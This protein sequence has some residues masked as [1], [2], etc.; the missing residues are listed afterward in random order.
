MRKCK[1][2]GKWMQNRELEKPKKGQ[3]CGHC[4]KCRNNC[5]KKGKKSEEYCDICVKKE[6]GVD[7]GGRR[8]KD[9]ELWKEP[10]RKKNLT[11]DAEVPRKI[12]QMNLVKEK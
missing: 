5:I 7:T 10:E 6:T 4:D 11:T 3:R 8:Y 9:R 1:V 12:K 2:Q